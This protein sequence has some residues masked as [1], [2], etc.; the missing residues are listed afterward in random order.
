MPANA[1]NLS[2]ESYRENSTRGSV[3]L[4]PVMSGGGEKRFKARLLRSGLVAYQKGNELLSK[5]VLDA[6]INTF[7]GKPL[8]P[9]HRMLRAGDI[10][11]AA[12]VNGAIDKVTYCPDDEWFYAEG[13]VRDPIIATR[14]NSVGK[15][16]C[17]YYATK[18]TNK[19]GTRN[20]V[21]FRSETLAFV[22]NHLAIEEDPRYEEASIRWNSFSRQSNQTKSDQNMNPL[23]WIKKTIAGVG[24][25]TA[26]TE[27]ATVGA[28]A[29]TTTATAPVVD[30][31]AS[32]RVNSAATDIPA[33]TL[34]VVDGAEVTG[35]QLAEAFRANSARDAA[36]SGIIPADAAFD[37]DGETVPQA[38]L[39][40]AFRKQRDAERVNS[41]K[42]A[43]PKVFT[44]SDARNKA[45]VNAGAPSHASIHTHEISADLG[46]KL[47]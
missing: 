37:V 38:D 1:I 22:G 17:A 45:M 26:A 40:A 27:P 44:L 46:K 39:I 33:D 10:E 21:P 6:H 42:P 20:K 32:A 24:A 43:A 29:D 34:F 9:V 4:S 41:A 11:L 12:R 36:A 13:V 3:A 16:S 5:P 25:T 18:E 31:D 30:A 19:P 2:E 14:I 47:F 15:V 23:K 28:S 35:E 7:V 8:M